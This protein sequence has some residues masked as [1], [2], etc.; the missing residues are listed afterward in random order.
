MREVVR[1]MLETAGYRVLCAENGMEA[2]ATSLKHAGGIQLLLTDIIMPRLSGKGLA[3]EI[4]E[5]Q[6]EIKVIFMSG[7]A[8]E[9]LGE[10]GVIEEKTHFISKPFSEAE[11]IRKVREVLDAG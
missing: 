8:N 7:Y 4:L 1:T 10:R 6:P 5:E 11:L 2:L 9:L 3:Q